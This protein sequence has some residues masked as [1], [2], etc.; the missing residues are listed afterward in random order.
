MK[1]S[2][3]NFGLEQHEGY[4]SKCGWSKPHYTFLPQKSLR[5][6]FWPAADHFEISEQFMPVEKLFYVDRIFNTSRVGA[7]NKPTW[8]HRIP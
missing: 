7:T 4:R 1:M 6:A 3:I 2:A 8:S 5:A